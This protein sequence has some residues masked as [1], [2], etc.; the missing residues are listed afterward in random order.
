MRQRAG[1]VA[2][3]VTVLIATVLPWS[4]PGEAS[5]NGWDS[6][7]FAL[8]LDEVLHEPVLRALA[9]AWFAVPVLAAAA[10]ALALLPLSPWTA[11]ALRSVGA[12]QLAVVLAV[13]AGLLTA[14]WDASLWGPLLAVAGGAGLVLLPRPSRTQPPD[15]PSRG[16]VRT[17]S[18]P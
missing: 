2:A 12:V 3:G 18:R 9:S 14:G 8:A 17:G 5:R 6:A 7:T 11:P 10:L 13:L 15:S 1:Y 4:S 16:T